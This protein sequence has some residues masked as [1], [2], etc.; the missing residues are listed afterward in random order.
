MMLDVP[1]GFLWKIYLSVSL[2]LLSVVFGDLHKN[3]SGG[4]TADSWIYKL[5]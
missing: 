5:R 2:T 4:T 1:F 3:V